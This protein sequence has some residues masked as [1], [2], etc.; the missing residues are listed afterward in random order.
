M[1]KKEVKMMQNEKEVQ[2]KMQAADYCSNLSNTKNPQ[3]REEYFKICMK[4]EGY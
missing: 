3:V 4:E 1:Q 2:K